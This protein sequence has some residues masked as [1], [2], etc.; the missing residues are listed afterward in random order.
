[1]LDARAWLLWALTVLV[2]ASLIRNPLYIVLLLLVVAI[3]DTTMVATRGNRRLPS[4]L[5]FAKIA[6]PLAILFNALVVH[7]GDTILFRLPDGLPLIGGAITLEAI[8]YGLLNGL[9]LTLIFAGFSVFNEI[10]PSHELVRLAPRAFH[11]AGV[12]LSI[13]LTFVPQTTRSLQR[14]REAQAVRGH[15]LR[16]LSDWLPIVVPLLVSGLERSMGLAEAMV[17]R[18]YG[19]V[20]SRSQPLRLQ[21]LLILGLLSLLGGWLGWVFFRPI[22]PSAEHALGPTPLGPT[23]ILAALAI[24]GGGAL[25]VATLW[26][27]GRHAPRNRYRLRHWSVADSLV[28]LG[29]I[30]TLAAITLPLPFADTATIYYA[31]YPAL[32]L[33]AFDPWIGMLL[34]GLLGPVLVSMRSAQSHGE[35]SPATQRNP[36]P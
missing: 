32:T 4:P 14:I 24:V 34:L 33:P 16:G 12:V 13:A 1:M 31:P 21:M 7:V 26:L 22:V 19:S 29:C 15:R 18:G 28:T 20:R 36:V 17:A 10:T 8:V 11:E 2:A 6:L 23:A 35:A 3:T 30:L 9:T 27:A 25:I 5:T